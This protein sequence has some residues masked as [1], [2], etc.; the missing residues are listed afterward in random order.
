MINKELL[1]YKFSLIRKHLTCYCF[2]SDDG[3]C[4]V[5]TTADE[6]EEEMKKIDEGEKK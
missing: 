1:L 4:A 3:K 6:I 2:N 5:C